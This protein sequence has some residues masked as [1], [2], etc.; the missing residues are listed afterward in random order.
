MILNCIFDITEIQKSPCFKWRVKLLLLR[1]FT[2][3][4]DKKDSGEVHI[5]SF[6]Y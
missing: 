5:V 2:A 6:L 3:G 1:Q 4:K